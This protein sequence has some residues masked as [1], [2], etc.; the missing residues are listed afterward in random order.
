MESEAGE[1]NLAGGGDAGV[2]A[3]GVSPLDPMT[4]VGRRT[5]A[6]RIAQGGGGRPI[7][8]LRT[9]MGT[10]SEDGKRCLIFRG[11]SRELRTR[12]GVQAEGDEAG[13][14]TKMGGG[15]DA[16]GHEGMD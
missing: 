15:G 3:D 14:V 2:A 4:G 9:D 13:G 1:Q 11:D 12:I 6:K 5:L 8:K 16:R 10:Q 7:P